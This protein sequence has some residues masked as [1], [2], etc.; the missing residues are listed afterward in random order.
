VGKEILPK[1]VIFSGDNY[2]ENLKYFA[3]NV[4]VDN[5]NNNNASKF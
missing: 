3:I 4:I 5:N 1:N 2:P